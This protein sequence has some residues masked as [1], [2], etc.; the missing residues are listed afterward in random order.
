M[1]DFVHEIEIAADS[2]TVR[3]L[4]AKR[5]NAWWTTNA[6]ISDVAGGAFTQP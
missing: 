3:D 5:G 6:V 2:A 4:I 1:V